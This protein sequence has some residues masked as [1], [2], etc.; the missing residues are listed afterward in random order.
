MAL[1]I[2]SVIKATQYSGLGNGE[3]DFLYLLSVSQQVFLILKT[4]SKFSKIRPVMFI[5][6]LGSGFFLILDLFLY[7]WF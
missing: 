1:S 4:N 6:D 2:S 5:P 3:S 7:Y